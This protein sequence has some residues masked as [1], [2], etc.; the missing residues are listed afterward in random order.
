[1]GTNIKLAIAPLGWT[2][3]DVPELGGQISFEQ[4]ISEM[5]LAGF[6]GCEVGSKFPRDIN[7]LKKA[8]ELRKLEICNQWF[9]FTLTVGPFSKVRKEFEEHLDFLVTMGANV[10][11]GGECGNSIH[12]RA[13]PV[14]REKVVFTKEDWQKVTQGL[15]ELGKIALDRG[16]KLAYHHHMGTGVQS[17]AE[18]DRLFLHWPGLPNLK[19]HR[20]CQ[21]PP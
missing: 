6:R 2:N 3:D 13:I 5:A 21:L 12:G 18:T 14:L 16:L 9:T 11:G 15:N 19:I 7:Q 10:V 4:C 1:M 20:K 8:L 17:I